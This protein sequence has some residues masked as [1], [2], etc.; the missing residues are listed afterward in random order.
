VAGYAVSTPSPRNPDMGIDME[1]QGLIDGK[2]ERVG[3]EVKS[4]RGTVSGQT[5]YKAMD[6]RRAAGL[7]RILI[8]ALGG[9]SNLALERAGTDRLGKVDLLDLPDLRSWLRRHEAVE[10][11]E[12]KSIRQILRQAMR[13]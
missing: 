9:Y 1:L 11:P 2:A 6:A 10:E 3:I 5:I 12:Q 13:E 8:I 4:H 7:D